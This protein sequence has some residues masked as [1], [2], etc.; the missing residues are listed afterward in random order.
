[1]SYGLSEQIHGLQPSFAAVPL[2]PAV[3]PLR[4]FIADDSDIVRQRLAAAIPEMCEG[5]EVVGQ[6]AN[7]P[8]A[9]EGVRRLLPD[10]VLLDVQMPGGCSRAVLREAKRQTP[11]ALVV[12]LTAFPSPECRQAFLTAGADFFLSK[13]AGLEAVLEIVRRGPGGTA[14]PAKATTGPDAGESWRLDPFRLPR[15]CAAVEGNGHRAVA[16][17]GGRLQGAWSLAPGDPISTHR[18]GPDASLVF[19]QRLEDFSVFA[20]TAPALGISVTPGRLSPNLIDTAD[21]ETHRLMRTS[22]VN[23][24]SA[25]I[26]CATGLEVS[27]SENICLRID[28]NGQLELWARPRTE[29]LAGGDRLLDIGS[30]RDYVRGLFRLARELYAH[31]LVSGPLFVNIH[32][33]NMLD[34]ALRAPGGDT[35]AETRTWV[36]SNTLSLQTTVLQSLDDAEREAEAVIT[37]LWRAFAL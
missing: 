1:M 36:S 2:H 32:L 24:G 22:A 28:R 34:V 17:P 10:V 15:L 6:A 11:P 19:R 31:A 25:P 14:S 30:C 4:I 21:P 26:P 9:I 12:V 27:Q 8:Q 3:R 13:A 16:K 20:G 29:T 33:T 18:T 23:S 7:V 5:A 35:A 37:R